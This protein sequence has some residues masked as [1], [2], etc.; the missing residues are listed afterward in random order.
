M[1]IQAQYVSTVKSPAVQVSA[2]S[3][4]IRDAASAVGTLVMAAGTSGSRIDD[5]IIQ[6]AATTSAGMVRLFISDG[7]TYSRLIK[8]IP[9]TAIT[10]GSTT[11]AFSTMLLNQGICIANGQQLRATTEVANTFNI[12]LTRAG[13]F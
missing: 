2:A 6:A 3:A 1:A 8:E 12:V 5:L 10:V 13:D 9:V 11:A 7:S 4:G